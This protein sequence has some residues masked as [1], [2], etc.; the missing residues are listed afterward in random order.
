M[1]DSRN[2]PFER[3]RF[4]F[5]F[6]AQLGTDGASAAQR[7]GRAEIE[8]DGLFTVGAKVVAE[9]FDA[10]YIAGKALW[11]QYFRKAFSESFNIHGVTF[12]TF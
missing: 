7:A 2:R 11:E 6:K 9:R 1:Y 12:I 5:T 8:R 4:F 10:A 3:G